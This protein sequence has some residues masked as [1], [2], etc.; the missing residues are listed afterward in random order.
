M[1]S[2]FTTPAT[3]VGTTPITVAFYVTN[4]QQNENFFRQMLPDAAA[5]NQIL[6]STGTVSAAWSNRLPNATQV[7]NLLVLNDDL[8]FIGP[9]TVPG[10]SLGQGSLKVGSIVATD[11]AFSS[12]VRPGAG[13]ILVS[14]TVLTNALRGTTAAIGTATVTGLLNVDLISANV[15]NDLKLFGPTGVYA[16]GQASVLVGSVLATS[17]AYDAESR[18]GSGNI[19][20]DGTVFASVVSA[21]SV[22]AAQAAVSGTLSVN[23]V[24]GLGN[25]LLLFGNT[26]T[27]AG[28][29]ASVLAGGYYAT[30]LA[31]GALSRPGLGGIKA[32]GTITAAGDLQI[33]GAGTIGGAL[34][35]GAG[36]VSAG[37]TVLTD[38][39]GVVK[40]GDTMTGVLQVNAA[41][42]TSGTATITGAASVGG[43]LTVTGDVTFGA[44]GT[45]PNLT[46]NG[47]SVAGTGL[48]TATNL[49]VA[50]TFADLAMFG[51]ASLSGYSGGQ[52]S[53]LV[54]S[55]IATNSSYSG[56]SR[57]GA[58]T[59]QANAFY[60]PLANH[61]L[62]LSNGGQIFDQ[63]STQRTAIVANGDLLAGFTEDQAHNL[64]DFDYTR[65]RPRFRDGAGGLTDLALFTDTVA[66]FPSGGIL[67]FETAAEI[68]SG[69]VR[70]TA[71]DGR[72]LVQ[73]GTTFS[74][75]F[76][77]ATS[78]GSSWAHNHGMNNHQHDLTHA[79]DLNSHTHTG[80]SHQHTGPSHT[81]TST[82]LTATP[83]GV[84][85]AASTGGAD[86]LTFNEGGGTS[87]DASTPSHTHGAGSLTVAMGGSTA[88]EGTGLSGASGTGATGGAS[89]NT[90]AST[91]ANVGG[92]TANTT[93]TTWAIPVR[94]VVHARKT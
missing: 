33:T 52:A 49:V 88:A 54:G 83:G 26:G 75:T 73:A 68:P 11:G 57:P 15:G 93:D 63:T 58:G 76:T 39:T 23:S 6:V 34:G 35:V 92:S 12:W 10:Y 27:Y 22:G 38:L 9:G 69:F 80:P 61:G 59:V 90:G 13:N 16:G 91:A 89:G 21:G 70:Y 25:D 17:A 45:I 47:I 67:A 2:F 81:H 24:K 30:N 55:V 74:V 48:V 87:H 82:G 40:T 20:A 42:G 77:E 3:P 46:A 4:I 84:S 65:T 28:G 71:A 85:A 14:G 8:T 5:A 43:S 37:H 72:I 31:F 66:G 32:D 56:I 64:F 29:Q 86:K 53:V 41:F 62:V 50:G 78:Y 18:P 44:R 1:V 36:I 51:P 19:K 94:T 60:A 7:D 79:H